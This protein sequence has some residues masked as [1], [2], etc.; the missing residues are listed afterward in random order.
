MICCRNGRDI[1]LQCRKYYLV[2][3]S[4]GIKKIQILKMLN[5]HV[6]EYCSINNVKKGMISI[7]DYHYNHMRRAGIQIHKLNVKIIQ[8]FN[9]HPERKV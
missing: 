2:N 3:I 5:V 8:D 6:G 9:G 1:Q 7:W 4:V